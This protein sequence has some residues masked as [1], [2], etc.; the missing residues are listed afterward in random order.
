MT[1]TDT[2]EHWPVLSSTQ[3]LSDW[4]I[5]VR[6]DEVRMPGEHIAK[7]LVVT[8][9]G[10]VAILAMDEADRVLMIQQY[11]HPVGELLW[12]IPAGLLDHDGE[13]P[14]EAARRELREETGY[15]ADS[16]RPL[17][18]YYSSPGFSTEQIQIFL[19]RGLSE[20]ADRDYQPT[21]EEATIQLRW[22]PLAD[23]VRA[24]L[25]GDIH[26]GPAIVGILAAAASHDSGEY[27]SP[28]DA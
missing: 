18:E 8:H 22:I 3:E 1:L 5:T 13:P 28:G 25:S 23:A 17:L 2:P 26:N 4:L 6:A 20:L 27:A 9:P 7:R 21:D 14:L 12:E 10:A 19:A 15:A 11:R 16:W 24:V